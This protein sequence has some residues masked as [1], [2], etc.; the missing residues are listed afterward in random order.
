M[1][2]RNTFLGERKL[3]TVRTA[4]YLYCFTLSISDDIWYSLNEILHYYIL[5]SARRFA[6]WSSSVKGF[7]LEYYGTSPSDESFS[8]LILVSYSG[9]DLFSTQLRIFSQQLTSLHLHDIVIESELFWPT[10]D[11]TSKMKSSQPP[12]WPYHTSFS[13]NYLMVTPSSKWLFKRKF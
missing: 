3:V 2:K 8:P 9:G 4:F 1:V 7:S 10:P 11:S 6:L 12:Y 5:I 13:V